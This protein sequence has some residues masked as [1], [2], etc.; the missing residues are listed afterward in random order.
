MQHKILIVDDEPEI[1]EILE[2][3]LA[4]EDF[5]VIVAYSA[6]EAENHLD[7]SFSLI[8][9]DVML[10]G[11]S[12]YKFAE[13]IRKQ[14]KTVPIIFLTAKSGENE[15]LTGFSVGGDDY[16]TKPFSIKE[17]V[18]R[19]KAV[20]KRTPKSGVMEFLPKLDFPGLSI[21]TT[22]KEI[23]VNN[24]RVVL[25]KKEFEIILLLAQ[26]PDRIFS[27]EDVIENLWKDTPFITVR[28]VDVHITRLR[29]KLGECAYMI[30]N[31]SG[32]GYRFNADK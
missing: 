23:K 22:L 19:V 18:A 21:D 20:I 12:G 5:Q 30:S 24:E 32:Y 13:K 17:V 15:M 6:E 31:R 29:K 26:N 4:S 1:C 11:I 2:F 27:R 16:I 25:T 3:N 7:D 14:G 9:L 10:G 8:L 28:T